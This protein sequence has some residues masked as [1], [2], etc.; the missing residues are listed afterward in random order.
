VSEL[1]SITDLKSTKYHLL[2]LGQFG[3]ALQSLGYCAKK[4]ITGF[5]NMAIRKMVRQVFNAG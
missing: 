2:D 4:T 1:T 5:V 3:K